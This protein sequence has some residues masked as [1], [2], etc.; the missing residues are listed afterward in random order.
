[1][2]AGKVLCQKREFVPHFCDNDAF[3]THIFSFA[4]QYKQS[5]YKAKKV[6]I[7]FITLCLFY[8]LSKKEVGKYTATI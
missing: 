4:T 2:T 1:M 3:G 6:F 8:F 5:T 7:E